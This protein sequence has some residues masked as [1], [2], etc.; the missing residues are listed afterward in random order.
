MKNKVVVVNANNICASIENEINEYLD[1]GW[2]IELFY[3]ARSD[4]GNKVIITL[5]KEADPIG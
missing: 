3:E 1:N 2:L 5:Y 4:K